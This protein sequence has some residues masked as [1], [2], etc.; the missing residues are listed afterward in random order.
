MLRGKNSLPLIFF[1][2]QIYSRKKANSVVV[3]VGAD[4]TITYLETGLSQEKVERNKIK[5]LVTYG[6]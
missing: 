5:E 6:N 2:T 1:Q 4:F 3:M